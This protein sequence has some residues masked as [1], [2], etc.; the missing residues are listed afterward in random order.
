MPITPVA[1]PAGGGKSAYVAEHLRPGWI[2]LDFTQ[3]YVALTGA[4]RGPDGRFPERVSGDPVLP[5]VSAV[6][7]VALSMAIERGHSGFV[8]T[9]S[10]D[11]VPALERATGNS[12]VVID[13]GETVIRSRLADAIT[14]S[15]SSECE[16]ALG[17]WYKP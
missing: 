1:G 7:A 16:Q 17:R 10:L 9:S 15:L 12:A 11:D 3:I 13:P 6:K 5:L 2:V 8:T 14:G 4:V